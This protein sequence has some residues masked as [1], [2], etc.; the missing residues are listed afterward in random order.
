VQILASYLIVSSHFEV[1]I[2]GIDQYSEY[3]T[4]AAYA[5]RRIPVTAKKNLQTEDVLAFV[6]TSEL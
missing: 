5:L 4:V 1:E 2:A 6:G 3:N